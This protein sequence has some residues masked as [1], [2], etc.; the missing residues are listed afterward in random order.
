MKRFLMLL[1]VATVAGAMYV[2][3]AP[4][5][6]QSRGPTERQFLALKK[7]VAGLSKTLKV[8]KLLAVA[9]TG[10][11]LACDHFVVPIDQFGDGVNATPTNGYEYS[12]SSMP[13]TGTILTTAL[14]VADPASDPNPLYIT[15]GD[16]SCQTAITSGLRHAAAKA[17][18]RLPH[19]ALHLSFAAHRP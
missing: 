4:G 17:G 18:L 14:D 9:D 15:G 8:V 13:N 10:L 3:A 19:A 11:L 6:Q 2:A 7:Q 1:A 16:S 12:P 5:S